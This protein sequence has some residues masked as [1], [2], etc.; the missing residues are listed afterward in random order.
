LLF[1]LL[2][3]LFEM[4]AAH[5]VTA[6]CA[7]VA[8]LVGF[9]VA[10]G[11]GVGWQVEGGEE[12][13][14]AL[15]SAASG[16]ALVPLA[17]L[18]AGV[19]YAF[20]R[21]GRMVDALWYLVATA[22]TVVVSLALAVGFG[23]A[24]DGDPYGVTWT[25]SLYALAA[26]P[27]AVIAR[28]KEVAWG[29]AALLLAALVQG[30]VFRYADVLELDQPWVVAMLGHATLVAIAGV[31]INRRDDA[32]KWTDALFQAGL[33]T[34][35]VAVGL[36]IAGLLSTGLLDDG[37]AGVTSHAMAAYLTWAA[38]VWLMLAVAANWSVLFAAFQMTLFLAL[39]SAVHGV[40]ELRQWYI[41]APRGWLDPWVIEAQGI[42]LAAH[43]AIW[44]AA[45]MLMWKLI[46]AGTT[47]IATLKRLGELLRVQTSYVDRYLE[48]VAVVLLL[49]VVVFGVAPGVEEEMAPTARVDRVASAIDRIETTVV[50]HTHATGS[51]AWLMLA[52]VTAMVTIGMWRDFVTVRV[53][54]LVVV[55]GLASGIVATWW[56]TERATASALRWTMAGYALLVSAPIWARH[57]VQ[58][59]AARLGIAGAAD[60]TPERSIRL[61]IDGW[62]RATTIVVVMLAYT[63]MGVYVG[64]AA[65]RQ[66]GLPDGMHTTLYGLGS[67]CLMML[68]AV[69][70]LARIDR[71]GL[72]S[73]TVSEARSQALAWASLVSQVL[74]MMALAPLV[75]AG[76]F[77]VADALR[78]YPIIGPADGSRFLDMGLSLSYGV[79]IVGIIVALLGHGVRERSSQYTVSAALL[80]NLVTTTV[81]LIERAAAGA[82]LNGEAW[83]QL[84]QFNAIATALFSLAWLGVWTQYGSRATEDGE[85]TK[86][87]TTRTATTPPS[88]L[89]TYIGFGA[90]LCGAIVIWAG[91]YLSLYPAAA[92]KVEVAGEGWGWLAVGLSGAG[93]VWLARRYNVRHTLVSLTIVLGVTAAM[94]AFTAARWGSGNWLAYHTLLAGCGVAAATA[95]TL[96]RIWA[97]RKG[98]RLTSAGVGLATLFATVTVVLSLRALDGDPQAPWWTIGGLLAM[99]LLSAVLA[100]EAAMRR[101]VWV[102]AALLNMAA[103]IWWVDSGHELVAGG[104]SLRDMAH[105]FVYI[106]MIALAVMAVY[107][108]VVQRRRIDLR[109]EADQRTFF[110]VGLHRVAVWGMLMVMLFSVAAGL[111]ADIAG[112]SPAGS[113]PLLAVAV[114][115]VIASLVARLWDARS[116]FTVAC[117]YLAG[118]L[119]MGAF[120][121]GLDI[122]NTSLLLMD[123]TLCAAAYALLTSYLWSRRIELTA[124]FARLGVPLAVDSHAQG[125]FDKPN[126]VD[127]TW[128][129]ATNGLVAVLVTA[130]VFWIECTFDSWTQRIAVAYALAA[131]TFAMALLS[132]GTYRL[133][134]QYMSLVWG[135]L[136][137][138]AFGF[139]WLAPGSEG[140]VLNRAIVAVVAIAVAAPLYGFGLVKLWRG[141]NEWTRAAARLT[142]VLVTLGGVLLIVVL[143]LEVYHFMEH[144]DVPVRW[145]ARIAVAMALVGTGVAAVAA[146]VVSG[147]DPL[148]LSEKGRTAYVY[149]AEIIATLFFIHVR[150]TV[151]WLFHG[152]FVRFWPLVAMAIAFAGVGFSEW[153][154]R[155]RQHVLA[156][157][158]EKTAAL[159][160]ILP[161]MGY[162]VVDNDANFSLLLLSVGALYA[163]LSVLRRSYGFSILAVVATNGSLWRL[164]GT[165]EGLG[166][167]EH[168]QLWLIPPAVCVLV[169]SYLNRDRLNGQQMTSIRYVAAIVIYAASTA[170]IFLNG[171]AEAPWLPGVLALFAIAGVFAGIMLRVRAFLFL[172]TTFLIVSLMTIIW[173]AAVHIGHTS[174]WWVSGIVAGVLIIVLFGIFEKRRDDVLRVV[175]NLRHW[176]G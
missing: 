155:R 111:I 110:D 88:L 165:H 45:R 12:L 51:G 54:A 34:S 146:A 15:F 140:P 132:R 118:V 67:V 126:W 62:A 120:L 141:E 6:A 112:E 115:A 2:A 19:A 29:A 36:L 85:A 154:A 3:L 43:C 119:G 174:V 170:D 127:H 11:D 17:G 125:P 47:T 26:A 102:S 73:A 153:C 166:L 157:P 145:A 108:V 106:N 97:G 109:E 124:W 104:G 82:D 139:S 76:I 22:A 105:N 164:L 130:A 41:A 46:A 168:P 161:V 42:A 25:L 135:V 162:W 134:L 159:L 74:L 144:G 53:V 113:K 83:V 128:L 94:L 77:V 137:A 96:A 89:G 121:D 75:A 57:H 64:S 65:L 59:L 158:L 148:G 9:H 123:V 136:F 175:D 68:I 78:A 10:R 171:V 152:W 149:A 101:F 131:L 28:R 80:V 79:P 13:A 163:V 99:A 176:D 116:R 129:V 71:G 150:V 169:A 61:T 138:V 60:G 84:A 55:A 114:V 87:A 122:N 167:A 18:F 16:N 27:A 95:P 56:E 23:F 172:G 44:T 72:L 93:V 14:R 20:N 70:V 63:A 35:V 21:V 37:A 7:L 38:A 91:V 142:P 103:S 69:A 50:A 133:P 100:W 8:W 117:L 32:A 40:V 147:R 151:P 48:V 5:L 143:G 66:S 90:A 52:A 1:A 39:A 160:P 31:A 58:S 98:W 49:G 92:T 86:I 33:A 24:R 156:R 30:V 107:S 81:Y 173:T 4:S